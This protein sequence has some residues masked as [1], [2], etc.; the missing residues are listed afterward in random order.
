MPAMHPISH[1]SI[2]PFQAPMMHDGFIVTA[3]AAR[4]PR[5]KM[6]YSLLIVLSYSARKK[7]RMR[8]LRYWLQLLPV[9]LLV[10]ASAYFALEEFLGVC[11]VIGIEFNRRTNP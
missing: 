10:F 3:Y 4:T 6:A 2:A 9:S 5:A 1:L 11:E 8:H 7:K